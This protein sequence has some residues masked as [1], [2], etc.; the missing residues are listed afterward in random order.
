MCV[1]VCVAFWLLRKWKKWSSE[2]IERYKIVIR[3]ETRTLYFDCVNTS[4][5]MDNLLNWSAQTGPPNAGKRHPVFPPAGRSVV[6]CTPQMVPR[7]SFLSRQPDVI[8]SFSFGACTVQTCFQHL[9]NSLD[10]GGFSTSFVNI[11]LQKCYIHTE[12][13][14]TLRNLLETLPSRLNLILMIGE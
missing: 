8:A 7:T 11:L 13:R 3:R 10:N 12:H 6:L 5:P 14:F 1:C 2:F 9:Q 4:Y